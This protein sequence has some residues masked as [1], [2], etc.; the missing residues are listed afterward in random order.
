M[1]SS[2]PASLI[3]LLTL[4]AAAPARAQDAVP[5][6]RVV[7]SAG[8]YGR[9]GAPVCQGERLVEPHERARYAGPFARYAAGP[10]AL[11]I[12]TGGLLNPHGV[13]RFA[14]RDLPAS[15]VE[16]AAGLGYD[17]LALGEQ[18]LGAPRARV[19]QVARLLAERGMPYVASNLRCEGEAQPLCDAV[20]DASDPAF[21][22]HVGT[23]EAAFVALLDPDVLHHVAP[24]RAEGLALSPVDEALP[25]AV[26][27]AR[28]AGATMVVA[29]LDVTSDE[30]FDLA[31]ALPE[32]GRPDLVIL[33]NEGEDL[34]LAQPSTIIPSIA[35]APP[36]GGMQ[37]L[38][39]RG[40]EGAYF[41]MHA[42]PL[43]VEDEPAE[44][45]RTFASA[46]GR[47]YCDAHGRPLPGGHL[48]R[49]IDTYGVARLAAQIIREF[50]GADIA[51][52][53]AGA[54]DSS[55][56]PAD[57]AH[58]SASDFYIA[59]EYDEPLQV[60]DVPASWLLDALPSALSHEVVFPGLNHRAED[61]EEA[62]VSDL[63]IRG[64]SPVDGATYRIVTIRFLA[65]GGD[66]ALPELPEGSE[67]R[68][69][70]HTL[71]DGTVRYHSL[72]DVVIAALE[73]ED[74]R[75]PRDARASTDDPPEWVIRGS[76]D[77]DFAGSSVS[78]PAGYD[79]AL[80][81]TETS[82][83]M[84]LEINASVDM[85][86]PHYTW[87]SRVYG[88]FRT[89]WAPSS[90]PG[91]AGA[92]VEANDQVQLRSMA[93]YR[94]LRAS[95]GDVW[96]PDPY[97]EVFA[98]T[99]LT[100]P[101]D[102]DWH[103]LLVRPTI[104]AR[105]PLSTEL[106]VKLQLGFQAQPLQPESTAELGAGALLLLRPWTILEGGDD[107]QRTLTLEGS[108]DFFWIDLFE[109]NRWQLR[110]QVDMALDLAGPL[111]LT[112]GATVY[113]QQDAMQQLGIAVTA[114]AGLRLAAVTRTV[115]P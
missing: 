103:W 6:A 17:V 100:R 36:G 2:R 97:L 51:F 37:V 52:L 39:E 84:G 75:D 87:E 10:D 56:R 16:L 99:E 104:G 107:G 1:R 80:L 58:L 81:A 47:A 46:V 69:L 40:A 67:W 77:G 92:F 49:D 57:P 45:V 41:D 21:R 60:A 26:L 101:D 93:S 91:T 111:A 50:A 59:L 64:R 85:T 65:A 96:V 44:P 94:G 54:I 113:A 110:A 86:A 27:A 24:D 22:V 61:L 108:A 83:A 95:P 4:F 72:R 38:L 35:A 115:G 7:A 29:V 62:E 19:V 53:N 28:A 42:E 82:I 18:D 43:F 12:D 109:D 66:E 30:A 98:E 8:V 14:A 76:I 88:N 34:I 68:T 32:G 23:E 78:N 3:L 79:A 15:L 20:L 9:F 112:L 89:Q 70:E 48:T 114:T 55:F 31:R 33:A 13:A 105:F 25:R 11:A 74:P 63:R 5:A 90:E 71:D 102:R 106:D 73:R